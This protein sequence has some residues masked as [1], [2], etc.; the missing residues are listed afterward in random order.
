MG[1]FPAR[2]TIGVR[3]RTVRLLADRADDFGCF[4]VVAGQHHHRA[5]RFERMQR[6]LE[7][8]FNHRTG[9]ARLTQCRRELR[10]TIGLARRLFGHAPKISIATQPAI[11]ALRQQAESK[12]SDN[13]AG[14]Q[15]HLANI[16]KVEQRAWLVDDVV[17]GC[18]RK[19]QRKYTGPAPP[20]HAL[21][22]MLTA[23]N[24]VDGEE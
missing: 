14:E 19:N 24:V 15:D 16:G 20:Y 17:D 4:A 8:G 18:G 13:V 21:V 23:N 10:D 22:A 7:R 1:L 3:Q 6:F 11:R 12:P 5:I 2:L 9:R